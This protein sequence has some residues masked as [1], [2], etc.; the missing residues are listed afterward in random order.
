M[1]HSPGHQTCP[2]IGTRICRASDT[3]HP[4]IGHD[5]C[6][7]NSIVM[8][9]IGSESKERLIIKHI[10]KSLHFRHFFLFRYHFIFC[11]LLALI[12]FFIISCFLSRHFLS[13]RFTLIRLFL[14][15]HFLSWRFILIWSSRIQK[16]LC[17][18]CG[19][20]P[21]SLCGCLCW[22]LPGGPSRSLLESYK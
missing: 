22:S 17:I 16:S 7:Q 13:W 1:L 11:L 14:S 12:W 18:L 15:R 19:G 10:Y 21:G 2:G 6:P 20:L 9:V 5:I 8:W 4:H 3:V